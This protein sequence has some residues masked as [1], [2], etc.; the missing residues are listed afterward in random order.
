MENAFFSS[1]V[2]D[3]HRTLILAEN[4]VTKKKNKDTFYVL[5]VDVG[6]LG[7]TSEIIVF[8]VNPSTAGG[9]IKNVVNIF[10]FDADH[11]ED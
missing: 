2:F 4:E 3:K 10:T 11:F 5:G 7:C 6:R 9:A 1:E 8:K